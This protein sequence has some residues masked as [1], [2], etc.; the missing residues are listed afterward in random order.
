[1]MNHNFTPKSTADMDT[2]LSQMHCLSQLEEYLQ[3]EH[4]D[5]FPTVTSYLEYLLSIKGKEKS[6]VIQD[7]LLQRNYGYQIFSGTRTPGRDKLIAICMALGCNLEE[8]QRA[9]S[10]AKEGKL[11]AK[12]ARDSILIFSIQKQQSVQATNQ[13]LYEMNHACL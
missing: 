4:I 13:L 1:M 10:I 2:M 6:A 9:L 3:Q 5:E 11:Y 12:D 8:T 7:A